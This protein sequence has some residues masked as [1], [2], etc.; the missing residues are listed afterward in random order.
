MSCQNVKL[1]FIFYLRVYVLFPF[2]F[3]KLTSC[4]TFKFLLILRIEKL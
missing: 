2:N 4:H 3:Y 1:I